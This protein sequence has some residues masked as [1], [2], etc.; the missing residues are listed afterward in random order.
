MNQLIQIMRKLRSKTGCPWDRKQT[1]QSLRRCILEEAHEVLEAI[2]L[3]D[4][5]K[6]EEELGDLLVVIAML[7]T[8]GEEKK[9][10][11][12]ESILKRA[13]KKMVSRHPHVFGSKTARSASQ[14]FKYWTEAK[15]EERQREGVKS[16]LS[17][18]KDHYPSLLLAYKVQRRVARV[19]FDWKK[20]GDVVSKVEEELRELKA[21]IRSGKKQKVKEEIGDFLFSSVNLA[22]H[23]DLDPEIALKDSV[24]KFKKRFGQVE[25]KVKA[26]GRNWNDF[27]LLELDQLW[28]KS[29]R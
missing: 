29:K 3:K 20:L 4:K 9:L 14:A 13:M 25:K 11:D 16:I 21:E 27:S 15:M 26:S 18:L 19:G 12:Q 28:R 17:G 1:M 10:F 8:M 6:I 5:T 23:L 7:I 2:S 22:R 24:R